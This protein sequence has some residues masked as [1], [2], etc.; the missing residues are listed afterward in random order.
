MLRLGGIKHVLGQKGPIM[1]RKYQAIEYSKFNLLEWMH[2]L[3][4]VFDNTMD[5]LVGRDAQ[6]DKRARTSSRSLGVF[7]EIWPEGVSRALSQV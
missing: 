3:K 2:N 7:R 6:F 5:L 4:C 1:L